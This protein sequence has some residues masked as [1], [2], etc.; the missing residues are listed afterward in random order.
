MDIGGWLRS[1]GLEQYET[2]FHENAIDFNVLPDLT[3]QDLESSASCLA[4]AANCCEALGAHGPR[5]PARGYFRLSEKRRSGPYRQRRLPVPRVPAR[6]LRSATAKL[7]ASLAG[8]VEQPFCTIECL[9]F[10]RIQSLSRPESG[11]GQCHA[12]QS[13]R[14]RD[15]ACRNKSTCSQENPGRRP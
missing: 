8:R 15:A 1:L 3:D 6:Y 7:R 11:R 5:G 9:A 14:R 2:A 4:I 10:G 13:G 12:R